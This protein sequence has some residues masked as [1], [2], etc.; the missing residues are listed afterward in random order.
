M[1]LLAAYWVVSDTD[2]AAFRAVKEDLLEAVKKEG[3]VMTLRR[4]PATGLINQ[5]ATC[6]MNSLLQA[7]FWTQEFRTLLYKVPRGAWGEG[8][9]GAGG[10]V[11]ATY[12][13]SPQLA[14]TPPSP[15]AP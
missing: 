2:L 5:G 12:A 3:S 6:Y 4:G 7:L 13:W 1:P 14:C 9:W 11:G 10:E 15:S 8:A